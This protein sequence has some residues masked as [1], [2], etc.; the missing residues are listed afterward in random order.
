MSRY[1]RL[2]LFAFEFFR[3]ITEGIEWFAKKCCATRPLVESYFAVI[4]I[5]GK[6]P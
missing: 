4:I 5:R 2:V 1:I 3:L 6:D